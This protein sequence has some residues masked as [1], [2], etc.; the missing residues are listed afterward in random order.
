MR[1]RL[2]T[3]ERKR[4]KKQKRES[5]ELIRNSGY[6]SEEQLLE[7]KLVRYST[8]QKVLL[9]N[10]ENYNKELLCPI[11]RKKYINLVV[12]T[13]HYEQIHI[14]QIHK[15][16]RTNPLNLKALKVKPKKE[17]ITSNNSVR[18]SLISKI[19]VNDWKQVK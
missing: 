10:I 4:Q 6:F 5:F 15:S 7:L 12:L 1:T 3:S 17:F 14:L 11:C 9:P 19:S 2:T 18:K 16:K 8:I 13:I